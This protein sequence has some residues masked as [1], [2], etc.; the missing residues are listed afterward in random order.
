MTDLYAY[1]YSPRREEAAADRSRSRSNALRDSSGDYM[2]NVG[3]EGLQRQQERMLSRAADVSSDYDA[4]DYVRSQKRAPKRA[5]SR[6]SG[7]R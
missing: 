2:R 7:R 6:Q 3:R 4:G 1:G 5:Q